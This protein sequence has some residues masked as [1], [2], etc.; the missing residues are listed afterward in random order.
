[1][2]ILQ[3]FL[4]SDDLEDCTAVISFY[5]YD[6]NVIKADISVAAG[7]VTVDGSI[8]LGLDAKSDALAV[9]VSWVENG[10]E[11]STSVVID[12]VREGERYCETLCINNV[13]ITYEWTPASGDMLLYVTG[14]KLVR[15][16]LTPVEYG[17]RIRTNDLPKL[18][19][20]EDQHAFDCTMTVT[21][22]AT[23]TT[24]SYKNLSQWSWEDLIALLDGVGTLVSFQ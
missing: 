10:A 1:M 14:E 13:P 2:E 18:L 22:G 19:G 9:T 12:T 7:A 4:E 11:D 5:L 17:F 21:P 8:F 24:P 15:L 6:K 16:I 3:Y 23:V 20:M